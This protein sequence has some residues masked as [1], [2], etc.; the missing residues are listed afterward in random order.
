MSGRTVLRIAA[1][2]PAPQGNVGEGKALVTAFALS[3]LDGVTGA[4]TWSTS[5][6]SNLI[7][8]TFATY[9]SAKAANVVPAGTM[10]G[11]VYVQMWGEAEKQAG[12]VMLSPDMQTVRWGPTDYATTQFEATSSLVTADGA[13][14][15]LVGQGGAQRDGFGVYEGKLTKVQAADGTFVNTATITVGGTP[16]LMYN[17]CWGVVE[18]ANGGFATS[19][20]CGIE[21]CDAP[22]AGSS[23]ATDCA[24]GRGDPRSGAAARSAGV[25]VLTMMVTDSDL[26][27][28]YRVAR[29]YYAGPNTEE[30]QNSSPPPGSAGWLAGTNGQSS[31]AEWPIVTADGGLALVTDEVFGCGIIKFDQV[32]GAP[33]TPTSGS[34]DNQSGS[35]TSGNDGSGGDTEATDASTAAGAGSSKILIVGDSMGEYSCDYLQGV[36]GGSTVT[37]AGIGGTT[38]DQWATGSNAN[39]AFAAAPAGLTHVWITLGGNDLFGNCAITAEQLTTKLTAAYNA[40]KSA[41]TAAGHTGLPQPAAWLRLAFCPPRS[42]LAP[43]AP[44]CLMRAGR[45]NGRCLSHSL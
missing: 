39:D 10:S 8:R 9:I 42:P 18:L 45:N 3:L 40:I 23:F 11:D 30:P 41:A 38:T 29:S 13:S 12:L 17:E 5:G 34:G 28:Q 27:E 7:S 44:C 25:W 32:G 20:A 4:T 14:I 35:E 6:N 19:C 31:A 33:S 36:C 2:P 26:V 37:N 15:V 1:P 16:E 24:A 43:L 21:T 22:I